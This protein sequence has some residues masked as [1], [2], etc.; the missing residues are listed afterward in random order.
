MKLSKRLFIVAAF[1]F[2]TISVR[3]WL[4]AAAVVPGRLSLVDFP[5]V[6]G[7]WRMT[8]SSQLSDDISGVLKADDYLL[9]QYRKGPTGDSVN[10][11]V[12]Y[13]KT[14]AAGESM[15]SPKNC[16]PGSGWTPIVNDRVFLKKDD[17]GRPVE[18]NRYVIQNGA[19][20]ALVLYWYQANGRIIASEYWGKFYLVWDAMQT[21]RRD[22]A[23]VRLVLPLRNDDRSEKTLETALEFARTASAE[24]PKFIPN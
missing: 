8:S 11:F 21:R 22:G 14:Q 3:A 18:V 15:H 2:L 20:R 7:D 19:E 5:E 9:R 4:N 16:L 1:L 12:A 23:I 24:L 17:Q 13:Y 6:I 10:L